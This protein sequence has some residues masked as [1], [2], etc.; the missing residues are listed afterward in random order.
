MWLTLFG[1]MG[2]RRTPA[3]KANRRTTPPAYFRP[4]LE[5]L[6]GRVVPSA[7]PALPPALGPALVAPAVNGHAHVHAAQLFNITG[8]AVKNGQLVATVTSAL[9]TTTTPLTITPAGPAADPCSILNLHLEPINLALLG[10]HVDTSPICL[11]I[12]GDHSGVLGQLLCGLAE[13]TTPLS[14]LTAKDLGQITKLLNGALSGGLKQAQAQAPQPG[15]NDTVCKGDTEIL[16]LKVGPLDLHLLGLNVHLDN[17]NNGP[18]EVCVSATASEGILG[19]LLSG[20]A[21]TNLGGLEGQLGHILG[22]VGHLARDINHLTHDI[23]GLV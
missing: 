2:R 14:S 7:A 18:V 12:T 4:A 15:D 17:C 22:D 10:L 13:G 9:G 8:V 16:D 6:E 11:T 3:P 5:S 23:Q 21:N 20:L 19:Q 1:L